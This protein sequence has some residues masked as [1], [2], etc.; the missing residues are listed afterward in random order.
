MTFNWSNARPEKCKKLGTRPGPASQR[1][2]YRE[3]GSPNTL[4][5]KDKTFVVQRRGGYPWAAGYFNRN[6]TALLPLQ[7][8]K[9]VP[10]ALIPIR[11]GDHV[12]TESAHVKDVTLRLVFFDANAKNETAATLNGLVLK[13]SKRDAT[14]KD[15]QIFSPRPQPSSG[16]ADNWKVNPNQKLLRVDYAVPPR[17]MKHGI[18]H[19]T[20]RSRAVVKLEKVEIHVRYK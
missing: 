5:H 7:L 19:L 2:A 1:Q 12:A 9:D 16:G 18:N 17:L 10:S 20:L 4:R 8:K 14:W 13:E 11:V 15:Y 6:D 3:I